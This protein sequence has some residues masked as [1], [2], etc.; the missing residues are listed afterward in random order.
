MATL[1]TLSGLTGLQMDGHLIDVYN[2]EDEAVNLRK[3]K[4]WNTEEIGREK[5][6]DAMM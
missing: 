3:R 5:Q 1:A 4:K 6:W 2:K